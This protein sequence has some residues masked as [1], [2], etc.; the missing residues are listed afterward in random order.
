MTETT[1]PKRKYTKRKTTSSKSEPKSTKPK[2]KYTKRKPKTS[3]VEVTISYNTP[4]GHQKPKKI[5]GDW[6]V[7][8]MPE[9]L[10]DL[11]GAAIAEKR[12]LV[13]E[14]KYKQNKKKKL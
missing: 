7:T 13:K 1:K 8:N 11:F 9:R 6:I 2:R 4:K 5:N 12:K 14:K 3:K 10:T